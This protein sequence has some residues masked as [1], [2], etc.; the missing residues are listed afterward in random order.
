[1]GTRFMTFA[2][3]VLLST[4][5]GLAACGEQAIPTPTPVPDLADIT[6]VPFISPEWG[7][8]GGSCLGRAFMVP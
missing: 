7:I 6:L 8:S 3:G 4:L 2:L 5:V 1:M